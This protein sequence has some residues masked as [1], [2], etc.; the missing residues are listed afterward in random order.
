M[1][2]YMSFPK[3]VSMVTTNALWFSNMSILAKDDPFEGSLPAGNFSHRAWATIQ[4]V[5]GD[6]AEKINRTS[7]KKNGSI[8]EKLQCDKE[9]RD[10]LINY[11]LQSRKEYFIS[12]WHLAEGESA[13]MWQLYG[14]NT[15][16]IAITT[17]HRLLEAALSSEKRDILVG[18]VTYLDYESA[19]LD[20]RNAFSPVIN[21][22]LD[23][24]HEREVRLVHWDTALGE[25][26][27]WMLWNGQPR[28]MTTRLSDADHDKMVPPAGLPISCDLNAI[29]REILISPRS[30]KWFEDAVAGFCNL[31]KLDRPIIKS[32]LLRSPRA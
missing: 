19:A 24:S 21:K 29:I 5:P 8:D 26:Q 31:A 11:C 10:Y 9:H 7:Y 18:A 6:V 23:Y 12:C 22:R 20:L 28:L 30:P 1:W 16:G 13:A 4:D 32:G 25:E 15:F 17:T 27:V 14:E 2:R 3:F